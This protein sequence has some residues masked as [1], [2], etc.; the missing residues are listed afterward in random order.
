MKQINP[1]AIGVGMSGMTQ[2]THDPGADG[3]E[4]DATRGER[5]LHPAHPATE[6]SDVFL[7]Q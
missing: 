6:P 2:P 7:G 4:P 3:V 1:Q 5:P